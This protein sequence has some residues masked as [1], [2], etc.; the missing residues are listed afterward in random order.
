MKLFKQNLL[1]LSSTLLITT[2]FIL[3][4]CSDD[5]SELIENSNTNTKSTFKVVELNSKNSMPNSDLL[6]EITYDD[7]V[8][9]NASINQENNLISFDYDKD[10]IPELFAEKIENSNLYLYK[11]IN[12]NLLAKAEV[13]NNGTEWNLNILEVYETPELTESGKM[14]GFKKCF[15]T[16]T[17]STEGTVLIAVS[18][19]SGPWGPVSVLGGFALGCAILG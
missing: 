5:D 17:S 8:E 14:G 13:L 2:S 12:G 4:S 3:T 18:G 1:I 15:Q 6:A 10:G 16:M 11:D 19:F 7:R 9:I